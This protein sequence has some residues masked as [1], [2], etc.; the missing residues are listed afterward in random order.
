M[1]A[2]QLLLASTSAVPNSGDKLKRLDF[3]IESWDAAMRDHLRELEKKKPVLYAGDLNCA[4]REIDSECR[5]WGL[6]LHFALLLLL[7]LPQ[8]PHS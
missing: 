7:H 5:R 1:V 3:R 2:P 4:H 6:N 8:I